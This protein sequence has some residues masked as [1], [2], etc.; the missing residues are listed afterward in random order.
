MSNRSSQAIKCT[1]NYVVLMYLYITE[2]TS[3]IEPT[4][5]NHGN[6]MV[7]TTTRCCYFSKDVHVSVQGYI[8]NQ[9]LML[10][11]IVQ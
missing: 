3:I 10:L 2:L 11:N 6:E 4:K 9:S 1:L 7:D 8:G 5:L